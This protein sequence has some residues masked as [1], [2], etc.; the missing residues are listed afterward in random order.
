MYCTKCGSNNNDEA[1]FCYKCGSKMTVAKK[2]SDNNSHSESVRNTSE[3]SG[4][5]KYQQT[6]HVN[7]K[8]Q[9]TV[10]FNGFDGFVES[11]A[12]FVEKITNTFNSM[13]KNQRKVVVDENNLEESTKYLKIFTLSSN[14]DTTSIIQENNVHEYSKLGGFLAFIY[15]VGF[16]GIGIGLLA[17]VLS[18]FTSVTSIIYSPINILGIIIMIFSFL[19]NS[20]LGFSSLYKIKHKNVDILHYCVKIFILCGIVLTSISYIINGIC[21]AVTVAT[22]T[23]GQFASSSMSY[24]FGN[25]FMNWIIFVISYCIGAFLILL[26]FVKSVRVRTYMGTDVYAKLTP[27]TKNMQVAKPATNST[28]S[29]QKRNTLTGEAQSSQKNTQ[30]EKNQDAPVENFN[31]C[32][33]C[34]ARVKAQNKF[35]TNCGKRIE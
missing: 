8:P 13:F 15:Y 34:G 14:I 10:E 23:T 24:I 3:N 31:V 33:G 5:T 25:L 4:S 30:Q 35:C 6:N 2:S 18:I 29:G 11:V 12:G 32:G 27:F 17:L 28:N 9:S 26:Y 1:V 19:F 20:V 16:I 21:S 22:H 7:N